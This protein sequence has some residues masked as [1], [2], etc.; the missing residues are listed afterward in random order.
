LAIT[1]GLLAASLAHSQPVTF[2]TLSGYAGN[3]SANGT[4]PGALFSGP[5]AVAVDNAGNVYVADSGNNTIRVITPG[6]ISSTLAG[7]AGVAGSSDGTGSG[8]LFNQPSGIAVDGATNIYVADYGNHTIRQITLAGVVT[9]I[10]GSAGVSGSTNATGTNALFFH[11][12]G[13]ALD[14]ATNLYVADY[15][16][17]LIRKITPAH[18][19]TTLAG[20]AGVFGFTNGTGT[21]A[22]FYGP[23]AVAVDQSGNV[24]VA[25]TGNAAIRAITPGG[26]VSLLAGSPGSLGSA[27]GTGTNAL[28]FQPAGIAVNS[29]ATIYVADYFNNTLRMVTSSGVVT[30]LAGVPGNGGSSD[31]ANSAARFWGPQGL[32]VNATGAIYVADTANSAI[33]AVTAAGVVNTLAGSPSAGSI[34]GPAL[35]ARFYSPQSVAEDASGNLYVADAQNS[36]IRKITLTGVVSV[37]AG[38]TGVFGSAD[39]TGTNAQFSGPQGVALDSSGNIYVANTGNST[40]RKITAG[41]VVTTLAGI[42]GNPGNADGTGTNAQFNAPQGI[43]VDSAANIY[44]ADT[45]NHTIRKITPG[46]V[47]STLAGFAGAFGSADGA[48]NNA[49]F[50]GPVGV[51]V[52]Q[53]GNLFVTDYNN[54]TIRQVTPAGVVSTLAG[55]AGIWGSS[56]GANSSA[57]FF[58]PSGIAVDNA[59]NLYVADSG[60]HTLRKLAPSGANWLVTTVAG[61][62]G[63]SGSS[64]GAGA[65]ARFYNPSGVVVN[66]AGYLFVADWGNNAIRTSEAVAALTW[67]NPAPITYGTALSA[68]QLNATSTVPGSFAYNPLLDTVLNAGTITL[69]T[70]FTPTD[71]VNYRGA[72]ATV[73]L[74]VS[75]AALT[76]TAANARRAVGLPNPQFTG[77]I[78]GLQISDNITATY[79]C[80]ATP[81]SPSGPYPIVPSLVDPANRQTNYLVSFVNGTLTVVIPPAFQSAA[82]SGNSFTFTWSATSNQM[83]QIQYA[84]NLEQHVWL[85]L[86]SPIT[87]T[88][89]TATASDPISVPQKFYRVTLFP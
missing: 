32:A 63:V 65:N 39:N 57:L 85:N 12:M 29:A 84:T 67:A 46:G 81:A 24:Y 38:S 83:Y 61:S 9:T 70:S 76:V 82:K 13:L 6:G 48:T 77:T 66:G 74:V 75:P 49:R 20:S 31:G 19:V 2:T 79:T 87:A 34:D 71:T 80:T 33:R 55:W 72:S 53:S 47:V 78:S 8:A 44:V 37:L 18:V 4:G 56:D 86:G 26:V 52:N 14:S 30:T 58:A 62:P 27:D 43:A 23:E 21:A 11:P 89:L 15:G 10:A 28:F 54:D 69:S 59:T 35:S 16:N 42:A 17:H 3:G 25:D 45:W 50:N 22:V 5:Q 41:G 60:N 88:N 40:I 7:L 36:T 73:N 68:S 1:V 64:D 51:T